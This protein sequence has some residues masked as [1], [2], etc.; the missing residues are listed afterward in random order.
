MPKWLILLSVLC[1]VFVREAQGGL[2]SRFLRKPIYVKNEAADPGEPLFLTPYVK[3]QE[4]QTGKVV[5]QYCNVTQSRHVD[6][7]SW[8]TM[9]CTGSSSAGEFRLT[10]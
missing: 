6:Q 7:W 3:K 4:F 5:I 1:F 10:C 2:R 9:A 8:I